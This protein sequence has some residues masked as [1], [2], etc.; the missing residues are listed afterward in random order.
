MDKLTV[1]I[2]SDT[3]GYIDPRILALANNSD[4][5]LHAG[6]IGNTAVL[7]ALKPRCGVHAVRGNNDVPFKWRDEDHDMLHSLEWQQR[8]ELPG[9]VIVL[10]HGHTYNPVAKR[11]DKLRQQYPDARAIIYGHSHVMLVDD[12]EPIWV[13]NPGAAGKQRTKGGPSCLMLD[14]DDEDWKVQE[15]R[16]SLS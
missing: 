11:H 13:L 12:I 6:D 2:I 4:Y 8:I 7:S 10:D 16:F 3:H 14:I 5:V 15:I 9:G 1:C